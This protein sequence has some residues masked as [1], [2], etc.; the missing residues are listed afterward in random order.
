M[1]D[2]KIDW[3]AEADYAS[4]VRAGAHRRTM[5][6]ADAYAADRRKQDF[7]AIERVVERHLRAASSELSLGVPDETFARWS[8]VVASWFSAVLGVE[9]S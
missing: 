9:E 8:H 5:E 2:Q 6:Q 4:R 7:A 1:R 3:Q